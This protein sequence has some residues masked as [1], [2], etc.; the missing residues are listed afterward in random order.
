[1]AEKKEKI[2]ISIAKSGEKSTDGV[3]AVKVRKTWNSSVVTIPTKVKEA[4]D[5]NDGEEVEYVKVENDNDESMVVMRR[6]EENID[7]NTDD[8]ESLMKPS[9]NFQNP[10]MN[11]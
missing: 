11:Q 1:M 7:Q 2:E 9:N 10:L 3:N 5:I 6:S 8:V 4:L